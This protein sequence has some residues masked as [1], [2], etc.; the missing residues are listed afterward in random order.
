MVNFL[1]LL[2]SVFAHYISDT[3]LLSMIVNV[4]CHCLTEI[5][6]FVIGQRLEKFVFVCVF[7]MGTRH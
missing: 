2:D 3:I 4:V 7:R 5:D 6:V 1:F